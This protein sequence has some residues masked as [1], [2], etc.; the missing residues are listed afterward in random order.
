MMFYFLLLGLIG[1]LLIRNDIDIEKTN[2]PAIPVKGIH[3][4]DNAK[5][6]DILM[7]PV[8][9]NSVITDVS[10]AIVFSIVFMLESPAL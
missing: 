4:D 6:H 5:A 7:S 1:F 9:F 8:S 10:N 2:N 3:I